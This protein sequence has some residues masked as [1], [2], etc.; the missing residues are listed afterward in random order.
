MGA[1]LIDNPPVRSQFSTRTRRPTGLIVIH[2]AE[3]VI[4]NV[5]PD[6]GAESVANFIRTR[7]SPGS[8][9][10]LVDSDSIINL[11]P[12]HLAAYQDGTGSNPF[13]LSIS[14]ACRTTDWNTM[15]A[16]KRAAF[17]CNGAEAFRRQRDWLFSKGYPVAKDRRIS[18]LQSDNS[19]AGCISHGE[20]DPGRRTD[21]GADFPWDE[22]FS[23]IRENDSPIVVVPPSVPIVP[24]VEDDQ[25]FVLVKG[26]L[27][28]NVY[29]WCVDSRTRR[30]VSYD[31]FVVLTGKFNLGDK[32]F[33]LVTVPQAHLD[34]LPKAE[35][36]A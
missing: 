12:Y 33:E 29:M 1:Y 30:N 11:V 22:F 21:P 27:V 19:V 28:P 16:S 4:D 2:T 5:G 35:G 14:F 7:N 15:G 24:I 26:D 23:A 6:T 18:K 31:E 9:H 34:A 36:E 13:A 3:S 20:R 8:Y 10:D 32:R 17:I 25:M